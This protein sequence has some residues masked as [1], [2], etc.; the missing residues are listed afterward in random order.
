MNTH[1]AQAWEKQSYYDIY[2]NHQG[3][4]CHKWTH[5]PFVYDQIF[6]RYLDAGKPLRLLEIGVQNGGS[7]E[8]WKKYLPPGSE[9]HGMDINPRCCELEFGDNI[10]F[11][12]GSATD[13]ALTNRLFAG[14]YFD[15][16]IDDGSHL[17]NEV[18]S[19]FFSLFNKINPGGIYVIEDLHTSYWE[20]FGGRLCHRNSSIEFFKHFIDI[21][22]ADHIPESQLSSD[23]DLMPFLRLYRQ[24]ICS[25]SFFDSICTVTRFAQAKQ[26]PFSPVI[27]GIIFKV[28]SPTAFQK[29][30]LINKLQE[31]NTVRLM[32]TITGN[33]PDAPSMMETIK[34][35]EILLDRGIHAFKKD[36]FETAIEYLSTAMA[37]KPENPLSYAYLAFTC[38]RQGLLAEARNFINQSIRLAPERA[39]LIAA[40][41]EV[42]LKSA[43][44]S[45]A[46]EYLRKAVQIQP[47]LFAA[48]PALAQSLHLTGQS[49]EAVSLLQAVATLPSNAQASIQNILLQ[50]LAECG[51]LSEFTKY[52]LRFSAGLSDDLLA[53]RCLARF[54]EDGETFLE[55]LSRIQA[56]LDN[57]IHSNRDNA[58]KIESDLIRVAFM[59]GEFTSRHQLEQLY[60]LF[61]YLPSELFFTILIS[62]H[63][64]PSKDDMIQMCALL[65]DT[66]LNIY[67]DEDD[68]AI[69]QL[70]ELA[71]DILIDM[72]PCAPLARLAVF[73]AAPAPHKLL[74][75]EAPMPPI[76]PDVRTLAGALL[77]VEN[78]LP[79]V[80]LPEIG[81]VFDLPELPLT[82]DAARG[83]P[84]V[85]GCLVPAAGIGRNGWQLFAETLRQHPEATLVINLEEL[86]Q[87]AQTFISG[88]FSGAGI[89]PARLVFI[90]ARTTEEFCLAWQSIDLGLLP[91][92]NPGGLAL[93]T[94]LWMGKPCLIPGSILPWSQRPAALLKALGKEEWIAIGAPHFVD[95]ARQLAPSR[96]KPDPTLRERM[97]AQGLVDAKGFALSFADAMT[98]LPQGGQPTHLTSSDMQ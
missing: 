32:Y 61:R 46:V 44:P 25:V 76:A 79:T 26:I 55:T 96:V 12:L 9:I 22:H 91:P 45:E 36:D 10:H 14:K 85:L 84:P 2:K 50:I 19:T 69:K 83:E 5:Y 65:A 13:D 87:A 4:A 27:N 90:N 16:I 37:E 73:L 77:A 21:L 38:A 71:P 29:T 33:T 34:K 66:A 31:I 15:I 52:T 35:S 40:L 70:R 18:I 11:H 57:V 74:W 93:P 20:K 17:C 48:Y 1:S 42:F 41:G 8:I 62:C 94:C 47:D 3:Y 95:L 68:S 89:D 7:L 97:T 56:Q 53:A 67:Q 63:G 78:M 98:G 24:E 28:D 75:A 51:D 30:T 82:D 59:V 72:Q 81:E 86:G 64:S 43:R 92:T 80:K 54:D 88:Q 23:M 58:I 60:A 6:A 49:A 39:D